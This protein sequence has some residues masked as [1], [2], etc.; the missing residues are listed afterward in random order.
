[1]HAP[2]A[3]PLYG[4]D[5]SLPLSKAIEAVRSQIV[6]SRGQ[7]DDI[8]MAFPGY[9]QDMQMVQGLLTCGLVTLH[10]IMEEMQKRE[11]SETAI[12]AGERQP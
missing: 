4:T 8:G 1:M 10:W 12:T 3:K 5:F 11:A 6:Q 7:L 9:K 2:Q